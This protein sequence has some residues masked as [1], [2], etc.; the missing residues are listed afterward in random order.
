[1]NQNDPAEEL[2]VS[3]LG[4][5]EPRGNA[6]TSRNISPMDPASMPRAEDDEQTMDHSPEFNDRDKR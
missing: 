4:P 2:P 6:R 5:D 3:E 1:M